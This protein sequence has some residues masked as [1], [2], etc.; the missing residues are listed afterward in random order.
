[1]HGSYFILLAMYSLEHPHVFLILFHT[2]R[3]LWILHS[4]SFFNSGHLGAT[5]VAG[6]VLT[7]LCY[8]MLDET[9]SNFAVA[10]SSLLFLFRIRCAGDFCSIWTWIREKK[11]EKE[12]RKPLRGQRF[13][14]RHEK[15]K[16][17]QD[18]GEE[19]VIK[20]WPRPKMAFKKRMSHEL[21]RWVFRGNIRGT[22]L[23]RSD[24][25]VS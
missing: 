12:K 15:K 9:F 16:I 2:S 10:D 22:D 21:T 4:G 7:L 19:V 3:P 23:I 6:V 13:Q 1:M 20:M 18:A 11:R 8:V 14:I 24:Q 17:T 25:N 5:E